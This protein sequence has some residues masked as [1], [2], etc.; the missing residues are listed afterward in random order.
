MT[1]AGA[2]PLEPYPGANRPWR[3][4]CLTCNAE[5]K[6][7]LANVRNKGNGPCKPCSMK[8]F[9][10][11][12]SAA[13][14]TRSKRKFESHAQALGHTIVR[15]EK[16]TSASRKRQDTWLVLRCSLG[17]EPWSV[18]VGNY[19]QKKIGCPTCANQR[20]EPGINDLASQFPDMAAQA[21]GWDPT[22][23]V[24]G[25]GETRTWRCPDCDH[26]WEAKVSTRTTGRRVSLRKMGCPECS[27][28]GFKVRKPG[29]FYV[30]LGEVEGRPAAQFGI[31]ND[32]RRR[33]REHL[34]SGFTDPVLHLGPMPGRQV[35]DLET[36]IKR[37]RAEVGV[38]TLADFGV[39]LKGAGHT[40]AF[41]LDTRAAQDFL[42][43]ILRDAPTWLGQGPGTPDQ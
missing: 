36:R 31:S 18:I 27:D 7:R 14:A 9:A 2:L 26:I 38:R 28:P 22:T 13:Q 3:C 30:V 20:C 1:E 37:L 40:E 4:R 25:S 15:I 33:L 16:R 6:P 23:I 8:T 12:G 35:L 42:T 39:R 24:A 11:Q 43:M 5:V 34:R 21:Y 19:L 17:H 41:F 29:E 10:A 32:A